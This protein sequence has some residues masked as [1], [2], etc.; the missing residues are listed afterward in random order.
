L[1]VVDQELD[2]GDPRDQFDLRDL[3]LDPVFEH[4]HVV[5]LEARHRRPA[6]S[7]MLA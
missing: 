7:T 2:L 1:A 6:L 5:R 3:G 4:P